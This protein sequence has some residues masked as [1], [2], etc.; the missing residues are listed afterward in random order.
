M[1]MDLRILKELWAHFSEL[2]IAKDLGETSGDRC[3][4]IQN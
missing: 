1:K 2:R 3:V 4:P